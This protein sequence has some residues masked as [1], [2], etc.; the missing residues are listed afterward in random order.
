ME[1]RQDKSLKFVVDHYK[2]GSLDSKKAYQRFCGI[3]GYKE[4]HQRML[5][6]KTAVAFLA[7]ATIVFAVVRGFHLRQ[8]PSGNSGKIQVDTVKVQPGKSDSVKSAVFHFHNT[9]VNKALVEIGRKYHATL[10]SN[11]STQQVS[12]TIEV[13]SLDE[14]VSVLENTL[15]ITIS[16]R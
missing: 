4:H 6:L 9:P 15:N 2:E 10:E 13:S 7:V 11:D 8:T 14:A 1:D 16:R 3:T 12:G 5:P